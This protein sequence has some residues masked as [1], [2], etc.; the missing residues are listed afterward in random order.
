MMANRHA[1]LVMIHNNFEQFKILLQCLD[2]EKNDIYVHVDKKVKHFNEEEFFGFVKKGKLNFLKNR[3]DV[4]WGGFSQ[5]RCEIELL[6]EATKTNH[7]YYH[8]ISGV[9][10]PL[11][12]QE[13]IY[14]F[15]EA[16]YGVE[17]VHFDSKDLKG[18]YKERINKYYLFTG[19]NKNVIQKIVNK[20]LLILQFNINRL[21]SDMA[22]GKGANWFTITDK[23]AKYVL[24]NE[25]MI[26]KKYNHTVTADEMFLQTLV[27][28]SSYKEKLYNKNYNDDY[29]SI[30]YCIDWNRGNPYEYKIEDY[31]FLINSNMLFARKFNINKDREIIEKIK[32]S[33]VKE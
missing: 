27:L 12:T 6:K 15:F 25:K 8:L 18:E 10:L 22:L 29:S 13:E 33:I 17:Y 31:E 23:L 16:S 21:K 11:K 3:I 5:I 14:N 28:N 1:Y 24:E 30:L 4:C 2:Y 20:V 9:D 32:Q 7:T 19:K 26:Y